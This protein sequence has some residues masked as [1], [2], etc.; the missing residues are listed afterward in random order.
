M[1]KRKER[2]RREGEEK[3][4]EGK[5]KRMKGWEETK[6]KMGTAKGQKRKSEEEEEKRKDIEANIASDIFPVPT[7]YSRVS[8]R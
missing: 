2:N 3:Q 6:K 1:G 4:G 5:L 7:L 8:L